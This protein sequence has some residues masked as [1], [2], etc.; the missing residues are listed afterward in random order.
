MIFPLDRYSFVLSHASVSGNAA[1][2]IVG[3]KLPTICTGGSYGVATS[4]QSSYTYL[5]AKNLRR[6]LLH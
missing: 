4:R 2:S 3:A 5:D 1:R 6:L